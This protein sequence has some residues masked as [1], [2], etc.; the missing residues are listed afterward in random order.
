VSARP[1]LPPRTE[2]TVK[3]KDGKSQSRRGW[4]R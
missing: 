3:E 1:G 2:G 4:R